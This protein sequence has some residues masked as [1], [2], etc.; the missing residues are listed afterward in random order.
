MSSNLSK[1]LRKKYG[2][3]S[4]PIRKGD[5]VKV[6]RGEFKRKIG[7]I[8]ILDL[9]KFRASIEN[10]QRNKK[11]GTKI[12]IYFHPS[13]LQIK[14]L[15]LDDRKRKEALERKTVAKSKK[16]IINN[17]KEKNKDNTKSEEEKQKIKEKVEDKKNQIKSISKEKNKY[18]PKT[19]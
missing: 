16:N 10:V 1:E 12:K 17:S 7:K 9:K 14:E 19:K 13:N 11:D 5:E 4:F 3:R 2:K 18:A 8:D 15:N 6:M